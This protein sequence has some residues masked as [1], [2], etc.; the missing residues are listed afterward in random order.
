[1]SRYKSDTLFHIILELSKFRITVAVA[2]TTIAG[3]ILASGSY[4]LGFLLP[5]AGI[6]FL[7]CGASVTNHLQERRTDA[8]MSRTRQRPL[9]AGKVSYTFA[10]FLAVGEVVTGSVILYFS[11]GLTALALGLFAMLWYNAVYTNMKKITPHAVI[12][13]SLIGS[14]PPLVG[15]VSAG[16]SLISI[17]ALIVALF[18]FVWQVPH[19]YLLAI[20]YGNEYE[21]GR[22]ALSYQCVFIENIKLNIFY[23]IIVTA[24]AAVVLSLI[25]AV[26]SRI[27]SV[28]IMLSSVWLI[29][30]FG[31]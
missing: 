17:Q 31:N 15:W 30:V 22:H 4:N 3:Y 27:S 11:A 23:W 13:G 6:F 24:L 25:P 28:I 18:F 26:A 2:L 1:M 12:P 7:A 21:K 19:F 16:A 8:I 14:I 20:K 5:T 9:P 29:F 10:V